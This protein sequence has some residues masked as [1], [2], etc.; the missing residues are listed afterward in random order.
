MRR[1]IVQP[2]DFKDAEPISP[3]RLRVSSSFSEATEKTMSSRRPSPKMVNQQSTAN[4]RPSG[5][6]QCYAY[7]MNERELDSGFSLSTH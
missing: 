4:R 5:E 2:S 7:A 1:F 6:R 3:R